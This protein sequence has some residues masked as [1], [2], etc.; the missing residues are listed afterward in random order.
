[1]EV[2]LF[3]HQLKSKEGLKCRTFSTDRS[4]A[5]FAVQSSRFAMFLH[6]YLNLFPDKNIEKEYKKLQ[7]QVLTLHRHM[8]VLEKEISKVVTKKW[9]KSDAYYLNWPKGNAFYFDGLNVPY[10]HQNEWATFILETTKDQK[11]V[12]IASS[13]I[14]LFIDNIVIRRLNIQLII[15]PNQ[16]SWN[17][18]RIQDIACLLPICQNNILPFKFSFK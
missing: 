14:N 8:E 6:R 10:N 2:L 7:K 3:R 9:N 1:M 5:T 4:L 11:Y 17:Q 16:C 15:T 13:I 18:W 12:G